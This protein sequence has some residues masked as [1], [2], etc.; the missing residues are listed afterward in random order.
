[1]GDFWA[2]FFRWFFPQ[3]R[4]TFQVARHAYRVDVERLSVVPVIPNLRVP[5]AVLA[6]ENACRWQPS[7]LRGGDL[8]FCESLPSN[9]LAAALKAYL[10]L[11]LFLCAANLDAFPAAVT[12]VF[13]EA[14]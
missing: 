11:A 8:S 5:A 1:L 7:P 12:A 4:A 2:E 14:R 3:T 6:R 9:L 10:D 13:R